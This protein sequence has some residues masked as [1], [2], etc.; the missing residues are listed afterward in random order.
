MKLSARSSDTMFF[1]DNCKSK[2]TN[3]VIIPKVTKNRPNKFKINIF[4]NNGQ[5]TIANKQVVIRKIAK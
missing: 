2:A 5:C 3:V 1:S 4:A